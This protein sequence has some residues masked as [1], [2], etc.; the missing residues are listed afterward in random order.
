MKYVK[1]FEGFQVN[2]ELSL[3]GLAPIIASLFLTFNSFDASS[4][5]APTVM[6][7]GGGSSSREYARYVTNEIRTISDKIKKDLERL[8]LETQD[9]ELLRLI[10]SVQSL[11][12][13]SY[14][15]G[16]D[17]VNIVVND[18]KNYIQSQNINERLV[19]DTLNNLSSGDVEL[20]ESD[21]QM[22][23]QKYQEIDTH[24]GNMALILIIVS[25]LVL[26]FAVFVGIRTYQVNFKD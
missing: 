17:K 18:L 2:E 9:P 10:E 26:S 15:N 7:I 25:T 20:I 1:T 21:Y 22:L 5:T 11:N 24:T 13:W 19:N 14:S 4:I 3:K 6:A 23:L 16:M 12:G 8:K